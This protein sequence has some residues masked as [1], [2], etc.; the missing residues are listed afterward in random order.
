MPSRPS[1]LKRARRALAGLALVALLPA[2][3]CA[4]YLA[5]NPPREADREPPDSWGE[6]VEVDAGGE[7][8]AAAQQK[9]EEFFAD[10]HLRALIEEAL[11]N[12][13]ELNI[14]LQEII[15]AQTEI[16]ARRGEYIPKLDGWVGGGIEKVGRFTSQ[17]VS[18]ESHGVAANLPDLGFGVSASWELDVWG[19]LR[20]AAKA[21]N[22]RYLASVE[23]R[24]FL[25]TQIIAEIADAYYELLALDAQLE[26]ID[27]NIA[28]QQDVLKIVKLEKQAARAT[29][30]AVQKFQAE[31]LENQG[32]K[33]DLEQRR[34]V[35]ENRINLLVGR[36]PQHVERDAARL[37]AGTSLDLPAGIPAE[38]LD[39]RPDVRRAERL[40]EAAKLD[41]KSAKARFYP[42][43]SIDAEL[44]YQAF[45]ARHLVDTPQSLIYS[46]AGSLVAPLLNRAAIKADYQKA[47]A[48]QIQAVFEFERA[49]L[50]AFTEVVNYMAMTKN[51]AER[52][53]R[54]QQQVE[55][56]RQAAEISNT[57]YR[58]ARADYM[59]VLMTRRD[60]LDAEMELIELEKLQLQ[61][62]VG[63]Y[64]ALGGGWRSE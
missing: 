52:Y 42:S 5:N 6:Q 59:E 20:N 36:Y 34:V 49:L 48:M 28:L 54:V 58:S 10:A 64:R 40:L 2:G 63:L 62:R 61:A 32:K 44:G 26:V 19:K 41:V 9:W 16:A 38:L 56:L 43:L 11:D 45:N 7:T 39:N 33:F 23:A 53:D 50:S 4:S 18:D 22:Q 60:T 25:V 1:T 13:Q 46:L 17:G 51:L 35:A 24:N 27:R 31:V 15:I 30:L 8:T 57:L 55:T 29:E 21:A 12:N 14:S 37:H 47:N 3:G